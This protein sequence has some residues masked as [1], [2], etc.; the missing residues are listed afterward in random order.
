[1]NDERWLPSNGQSS[2]QDKRTSGFR[3]ATSRPLLRKGRATRPR[4]QECCPGAG[5]RQSKSSPPTKF[6]RFSYFAIPCKYLNLQLE[7]N[8]HDLAPYQP[9]SASTYSSQPNCTGVLLP[10]RT[11]YRLGSGCNQRVEALRDEQDD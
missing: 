2:A 5:D 8:L 1:M 6:F 9:V 10:P 11:L 3:G 7:R 4:E